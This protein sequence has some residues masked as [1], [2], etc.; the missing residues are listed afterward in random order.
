MQIYPGRGA[1][2]VRPIPIVALALD[3]TE[4]SPEALVALLAVMVELATASHAMAA[5][6]RKKAE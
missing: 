3:E 4:G 5:E 6:H 2:L 1:S